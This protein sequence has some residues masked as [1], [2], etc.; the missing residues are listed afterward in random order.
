MPFE[1]ELPPPVFDNQWI[2]Q[3]EANAA[4]NNGI[5]PNI[6][7]QL[8]GREFD[9]LAVLDDELSAQLEKHLQEHR[10]DLVSRYT[11]LHFLRCIWT[12]IR[13]DEYV[14]ERAKTDA[15]N[16]LIKFL[17]RLEPDLVRTAPHAMWELKQAWL[18]KE[19][20]RLRRLCQRYVRLVE[21]TGEDENLLLGRAYWLLQCDER[22]KLLP[23]AE[24]TDWPVWEAVIEGHA[25]VVASCLL[26]FPSEIEKPE[27]GANL[28]DAKA[29]FEKAAISRNLGVYWGLLADCAAKTGDPGRAASIWEDHWREIFEPFADIVG[30]PVANLQLPEEWQFQIAD[31]WERAKRPD[32]ATPTLES[33]RAKH[34]GLKGVNRRLFEIYSRQ[35]DD[36]L[37]FERFREEAD[38][39]DAFGEDPIVSFALRAPFFDSEK[40]ANRQK[41]MLEG[42]STT[43]RHACEESLKAELP[44]GYEK[45]TQKARN[46]L[47]A[48]EQSYRIPDFA[49]PGFI[50]HG[51]ALAFELELRYSVMSGLFDHLKYRKVEKLRVP[52]EWISSGYAEKRDKPLWWPKA[53]ADK[54]ALGEMNLILGH[55]HPAIGE[56]FAQFGLNLTDIRGATKSVYSRR[57][58]ATHGEHFDIATAKAIRAGWFHWNDRPGGIFSVFFRNQ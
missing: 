43:D 35:G 17:N 47:L 2:A 25:L 22:F 8:V 55:P 50:V 39:D 34:P 23:R 58:P 28:I 51:L 41:Q 27:G 10:D 56:F 12:D 13:Q 53:K 18:L 37:A 7:G 26:I 4:E 33:L 32:K 30:V 11:V 24:T 40:L 49:A 36:A 6:L 48:S 44:G 42:K 3:H 29:Y 9:F 45:L 20:G 15:W 5:P 38:C 57:N 19:F 14:E 16:F 52:E 54:C 46:S 1:P 31:L 21:D